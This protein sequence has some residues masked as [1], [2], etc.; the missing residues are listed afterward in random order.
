MLGE[1]FG[2]SGWWKQTLSSF[3]HD[4]KCK[5]PRV[6]SSKL[7]ALMRSHG[8]FQERCLICFAET[9]HWFWCSKCSFPCSSLP[10]QQHAPNDN[11][12]QNWKKIIIVLWR[13]WRWRLCTSSW[14]L[15]LLQLIKHHIYKGH[16]Y[17]PRHSKIEDVVDVNASPRQSCTIA[18]IR[19]LLDAENMQTK[20]REK[21]A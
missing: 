8:E 18:V 5:V 12:R 21:S 10:E 19:C 16:T 13:P 3:H 17:L 14:I 15:K 20:K 1:L 9:W 7:R 6:W 11:H 4:W 2:E